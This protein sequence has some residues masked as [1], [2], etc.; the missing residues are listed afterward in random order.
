MKT[1]SLAAFLADRFRR[2]LTAVFGLMIFGFAYYMQ[3]TVTIGMS[4]WHTFN[5]GLSLIFPITV[6]QASILVS[7]AVVC[8]DLL[9]RE[10]IGVGTLLDAVTVGWWVDLFDSMHLLPRVTGLLPSV[11]MLLGSIVIS[12][13]SQCIYMRARLS[14]GP[15]DAMIVAL[16]RRVKRI[17]MGT[18]FVAIQL[19][20]LALGVLMGGDLGLGTLINLLATGVIMDAVYRLL[21]F[22]PRDLQQEGL[23]DTLREFRKALEQK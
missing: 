5:Q 2:V 6:G 17:S 3:M 4:P 1:S 9:L 19:V 7:V 8:I 13:V 12:C 10:P 22:E 18:V 23:Q 14:C 16:G 15:P 11:A 20:V 21:R